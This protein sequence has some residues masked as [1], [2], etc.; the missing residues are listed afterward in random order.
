MKFICM[1]HIIKWLMVFCSNYDM[2]DEGGVI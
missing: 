2:F 1:G